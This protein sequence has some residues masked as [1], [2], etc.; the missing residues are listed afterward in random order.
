LRQ[1]L[2]EPLSHTSLERVGER[3]ATR[4]QRASF[5]PRLAVAMTAASV[6]A[7][8]LVQSREPAP[9]EANLD[10]VPSTAALVQRDG[11][12]LAPIELS[13]GEQPST[14]ELS[15]GTRVTL[16]ARS[17]LVPR[18][19]TAERCELSLEQ[20]A[21]R[22]EVSP[23]GSRRFIVQAGSLRVEV[24]GTAFRV[25]RTQDELTLVAVEHGRVRVTSPDG[26]HLLGKGERLRF[27]ERAAELPSASA[28]QP[29]PQEPLAQVALEPATVSKRAGA[30]PPSGAPGLEPPTSESAK[31]AARDQRYRKALAVGDHAAAFAAL[32]DFSAAVR[33]AG[34]AADL[35]ELADVARGARMPREASHALEQVLVRHAKDPRAGLAALTLGKLELDVLRDPKRAA[36][37]FQR[38]LELRLP[39]ALHEDALARY[40]RALELSGERQAAQKAAEQY[41]QRYPDGAH[42]LQLE[43]F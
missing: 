4:R 31:A 14:L 40:V 22:F 2:R 35:L 20:G 29:E 6:A 37:S 33:R 5:F 3:V 43:G 28:S 41:K 19:S 21:A 17:R 7:L 36:K 13:P 42:R 16:Y 11:A 30:L 24:V 1:L 38:A 15:D 32:G 8:L 18:K 39:S 27:S 9:G 10:A 12:P 34:S 23:Q 26:E 25:E